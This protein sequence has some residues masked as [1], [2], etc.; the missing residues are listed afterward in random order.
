LYTSS[1]LYVLKHPL[2]GDHSPMPLH[3]PTYLTNDENQL[4][5]FNVQI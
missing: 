3:H 4:V 5:F 2:E 1:N